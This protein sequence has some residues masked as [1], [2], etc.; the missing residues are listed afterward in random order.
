[1]S[2]PL[3]SKYKSTRLVIGVVLITIAF[4]F[5]AGAYEASRGGGYTPG[6]RDRQPLST[7]Q[8]FIGGLFC[9]FFGGYFLYAHFQSRCGSKKDDHDA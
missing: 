1:M 4:L 9:T 3:P 6:S 7:A 5:F 8:E 2:N